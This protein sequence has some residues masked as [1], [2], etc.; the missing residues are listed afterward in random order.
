M[1]LNENSYQSLLIALG[2]LALVGTAVAQMPD[3]NDISDGNFNTGMGTF[4]LIKP[5]HWQQQHRLRTKRSRTSRPE[6]TTPPPGSLRSLSNNGND[7]T[8]SG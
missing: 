8:A 7:N 6:A 4:S 1:I 5:P 2:S 3:T